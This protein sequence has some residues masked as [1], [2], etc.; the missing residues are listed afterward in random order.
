M[1]V[2]DFIFDFETR[3]RLDLKEVGTVRYACHPSTEATLITYC[4]GKHGQ[5]NVWRIGQPIPADLIEV[6]SNPQNY[7][8]IAF[9]VLFD[10][11]IWMQS[12]LSRYGYAVNPIP[13]HNIHDCMA[14]SAHY[15]AGNSLNSAAKMFD[16]PIEKDKKGRAI[17]LKQCKPNRKGEFPTLTNE[18]WNHFI[19][20]G[21]LDTRILRE[22]YYR[23]PPLPAQERW[24]WEWTF[25]RNLRGIKIDV[26]LVDTMNRI[27][28][29]EYPKFLKLFNYY[30]NDVFTIKSATKCKLWFQQFWPEIKDMRKDTVRDMLMSSEGKPNHAVEALKIK[31]EAGSNAISKISVAI[32][33][34]HAGRLY[35]TLVY[36]KAQTKRWAGYGIQIQNM[37]RPEKL[38]GDSALE[39][40]RADLCQQLQAVET[41]LQ[42]PLLFVKNLIRRIWIPDDGLYFYCGDFSKIEP[43]VLRWLAGMGAIPPL[44]Y[45]EMA[46]AIYNIP[47]SEIGKESEERQ[48]GKAAELGGGYGMGW[49]KFRDDVYEKTGIVLHND[50]AKHVIK[51]YRAK[52]KAIA[53]LWRDIEDAFR[54]AVKGDSVTI[55]FGKVVIRPMLTHKGV[56]IVL[57]SKGKLYYHGAYTV[58]ET[59]WQEVSVIRDGVT[60]L[61]KKS[62][63]RENLYYITDDGGAVKRNKLY[64]GQ[65]TEHI[66]SSIARELL[67][68]SMWRLE[69]NGFEVLSCVHDEIWAQAVIGR[70][71]EFKSLM[72]ERPSWAPDIE[73]DA[74][75]DNGVRYLK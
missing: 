11:M 15:R 38:S 42:S 3:S 10:Y 1:N 12:F 57:P 40:N 24:V 62:V 48:I 23:C 2:T 30:T 75:L 55:C 13:L 5:V 26:P 28:E 36:H 37:P 14:V 41:T 9:N 70:D 63:T 69:Q 71:E 6:A 51:T 35:N 29:R 50:M 8:F 34:C 31:K 61:E 52:N 39:L 64:G 7:N 68:P 33:Q 43:T 45:E 60:H 49:K 16:L 27:V 67:T 19:K 54:R 74:G 65:L 73:I 47:V 22:V 44:V 21:V 4:F 25:T 18:E 56:E 58:W 53:D 59:E 17:M 32:N 20:Y 72:C 46:E 66:T